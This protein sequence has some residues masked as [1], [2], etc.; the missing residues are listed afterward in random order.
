M[1]K[2][3]LIKSKT[4]MMVKKRIE[5]NAGIHN[6]MSTFSTSN[7]KG[8]DHNVVEISGNVRLMSLCCRCIK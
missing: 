8:G 1:H 5:R 4:E 3:E 7:V 6:S 2:E